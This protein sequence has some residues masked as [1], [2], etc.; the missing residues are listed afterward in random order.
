MVPRRAAGIWH[1]PGDVGRL[2]TWGLCQR[3]APLDA[4]GY[5]WVDGPAERV[6]QVQPQQPA[7]PVAFPTQ[8]QAWGQAWLEL[9]GEAGTQWVDNPTPPPVQDMV[10]EPSAFKK[11]HGRARCTNGWT[12]PTTAALRRTLRP[13]RRSPTCRRRPTRTTQATEVARLA[14]DP[15]GRPLCHAPTHAQDPMM[16][17]LRDPLAAQYQAA[18]A[19][20]VAWTVRRRG[21]PIRIPTASTRWDALK[22]V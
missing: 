9:C 19:C 10:W 8:P 3:V 20:G 12:L 14:L 22:G 13:R 2:K 16:D 7:A 18:S 1:E 11:S 17:P 6:P 4:E 15:R 5:Q 21:S